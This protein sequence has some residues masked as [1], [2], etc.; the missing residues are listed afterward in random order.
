MKRHATLTLAGGT[1]MPRRGDGLLIDQGSP[2]EE[3]L[4]VIKVNGSEVTVGRWRWYHAWGSRVRR[5]ARRS[6]DTLRY[7]PRNAI[8][9]LRGHRTTVMEEDGWWCCRGGE[10]E[11]RFS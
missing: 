7:G 2:Y 9:S 4:R 1:G 8:C 6:A 11:G 5:W 10:K 3:M